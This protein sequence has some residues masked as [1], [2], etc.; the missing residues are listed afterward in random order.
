MSKNSFG[1][2]KYEKKYV[3][4]GVYE[5]K[6]SNGR[7]T[8]TTPN[9]SDE[10]KDANILKIIDKVKNF[11]YYVD[12]GASSVEGFAT[13]KFIGDAAEAAGEPRLAF[14]YQLLDNFTSKKPTAEKVIDLIK[15]LSG[16]IKVPNGFDIGD[17]VTAWVNKGNCKDTFT[18][19]DALV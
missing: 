7:K 11:V 15:Q 13:S 10:S 9:L 3:Y 4:R 2:Y 12:N 19:I 8:I 16:L 17:F 5:Y 14:V 6:I 1:E 18:Q